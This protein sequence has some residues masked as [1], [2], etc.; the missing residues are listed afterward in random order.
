MG[1]ENSYFYLGPESTAGYIV[2][3]SNRDSLSMNYFLRPGKRD[4]SLWVSTCVRAE[5]DTVI[6]FSF[7]SLDQDISELR[8]GGTTNGGSVPIEWRLALHLIWLTSVADIIM[9]LILSA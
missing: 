6:Y 5:N 7:F 8:T 1:P 4:G 9:N 3:G 2:Y